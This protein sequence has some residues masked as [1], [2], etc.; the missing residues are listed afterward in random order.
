[1]THERHEHNRFAAVA[2]AT[3]AI[4]LVLF[5]AYVAGYFW[6]G[7]RTVWLEATPTGDA[8]TCVTRAYSNPGLMLIYM[9]VSKVESWFCRM[10]VE[11]T[12]W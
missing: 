9:P 7:E 10:E 6:L 12:V 11:T 1:M 4:L 2:F 5:G 3:V 8:P